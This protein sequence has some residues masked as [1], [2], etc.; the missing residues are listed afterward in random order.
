MGGKEGREEE[1]EDEIEKNWMMADR[2]F[3]GSYPGR[4][5]SCGKQGIAFRTDGN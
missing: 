3:L 1:R 4:T 5:L 2:C